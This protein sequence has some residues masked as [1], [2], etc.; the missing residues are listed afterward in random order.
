MADVLAR[1]QCSVKNPSQVCDLKV[2]R[3][4]KKLQIKQLVYKMPSILSGIA[5]FN[6]A[7][8]QTFTLELPPVV[9]QADV[10]G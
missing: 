3:S 9:S 7:S 10:H 5:K 6:L 8:A 2:Q 4:D 1:L